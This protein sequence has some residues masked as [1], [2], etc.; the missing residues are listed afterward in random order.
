[1]IRESLPYGE[2]GLKLVKPSDSER[3]LTSLPYGERGLK[4]LTCLALRNQSGRSLTGSV[5]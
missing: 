3:T 2:R 4:H 1:M 5:D